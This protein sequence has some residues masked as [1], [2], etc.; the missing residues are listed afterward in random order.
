MTVMQLIQGLYFIQ[1]IL[2]FPP[3]DVNNLI[4]NVS[5]H[6][7]NK[8]LHLLSVK[9]KL[10]E[11]GSVT[12]IVSHRCKHVEKMSVCIL[13]DNNKLP[14]ITAVDS[15][16]PVTKIEHSPEKTWWGWFAK[17]MIKIMFNDSN[18]SLLVYQIVTDRL[19]YSIEFLQNWWIFVKSKVTTYTL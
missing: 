12:S 14:L 17:I 8:M 6:H 19:I 11:L 3:C 2:E 13:T 18:G 7:F 15:I 1:I 4:G 16:L 10:S 9:L 5:L